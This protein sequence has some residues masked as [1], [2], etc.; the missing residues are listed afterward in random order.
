MHRTS[1]QLERRHSVALGVIFMAGLIFSCV[2]ARPTQAG[3]NRATGVVSDQLMTYNGAQESVSI[4]D[5]VSATTGL[6]EPYNYYFEVSPSLTRLVIEM[7]DPD[8]VMGTAGPGATIEQNNDRDLRRNTRDTFASYKLFDPSGA[9]VATQ[10]GVGRG[11]SPTSDNAWR[12]LYDSRTIG[13]TGGDTFSDNFTT[14]VYNRDDGSNN[15]TGDWTEVNELGT[16]GP[17]GGMLRVDASGSGHLVITNVGDTGSFVNKPGIFREVNLSSFTAANL[18]FSWST[19]GTLE[20]NDAVLIEA[21]GDGGTSWTG[22][23][24][25]GNFSSGASSGTQSYDI[26]PFIATNTRLRFSVFDLMAGTDGTFGDERFLIDTVTVRGTNTTNSA[27]PTPGHWRLI[28]DMS[29]DTYDRNF[30]QNELN[31]LAIRAHDGDSTAAGNEVHVYAPTYF[32]FGL[33]NNGRSRSYNMYPYINEGCNLRVNDFD[34]DSGAADPDGAGPITPPY[35]SW[36]LT[37]RTAAF[38]ANDGGVLSDNNRWFSALVSGWTTN[39]T[40]AD[41]GIW[42]LDLTVQDF[43]LGNYAMVYVGQQD[44]ADPNANGNGTPGPTTSPEANTHRIYFPTDANTA[45]A[46]PYVRQAVRWR[47]SGPN[48]PVMGST[49]GFAVTIAVT[50]PA[51]SIGNITF[52]ASHLISAFI[53]ADTA[54]VDY[55]YAGLAAGFPTSGTVTA[56]SLGAAGATLT[57]NPGILAPGNTATLVYRVD[58]QPLVATDPLTVPMTGLYN[59]ANATSANFIDETGNAGL[60]FVF[61]LCGLNVIAGST[62]GQTPVLVS[63]FSGRPA[64]GGMEVQWTTAAEAGTSTFELLRDNAA[65]IPQ[66]VSRQPLLALLDSPQGGT[67][68]YLDRTASTSHQQTYRL[69]ETTASGRRLMHG[70]FIVEADWQLPSG[71][72]WPLDGFERRAHP[73]E[74]QVNTGFADPPTDFAPTAVVGVDV[75]VDTRGLYRVTAQDLANAFGLPTGQIRSRIERHGLSLSY[76]GKEVT[77]LSAGDGRHLDFFA[78]PAESVHSRQAV[79]RLRLGQGVAMAKV[80]GETPPIEPGGDFFRDRRRLEKNLRPAVLLP[81]DPLGDIFFWDFLRFG[82]AQHGRKSFALDLPEVADSLGLGRLSLELQGAGTG[83]HRLDVEINGAPLGTVQVS[84]LDAGRVALDLPLDVLLP[85]GNTLTLTTTGGSLVFLNAVSVDYDRR[86]RASDEVLISR[87][88]GHRRVVVDGFS[89]PHLRVFDITQPRGPRELLGIRVLPG[90]LPAEHRVLWRPAKAS[91]PYLAISESGVLAPLEL[92]PDRQSNLRRDDNAADYLVIVPREMADAAQALAAL[93]AADGLRTQVVL[94]QDIYDEFAD[95]HREWTALR[96]FLTFTQ[97]RWSTAPRFVVLAGAGTYD[98]ADHSGLGG[99]HIPVPLASDGETLFA[100]DAV[101]ADG[102]VR[103]GLPEIAIGRLPALDADQLRALVNKIIA[104]GREAGGPGERRLLMAADNGDNI[105]TYGQD[106]DLLAALVPLGFEVENVDLETADLSQARQHLF[107]GLDD[108]VSILHYIGHGGVDRLAAEGLLTS[109]DVPAL[110]NLQ[111]PPLVIALSC[112][113]GLHGLPGFDSLGEHLL[114]SDGG[115]IAVIAPAWLSRHGEAQVLGDR[116]FRQLFVG[117]Q[118]VLGTA[119]LQAMLDAG[120][121]G[122]DP[123]LLQ[124]YQLLGDP[125]MELRLVP[126][127]LPG[128]TGCNLDCGGG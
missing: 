100:T 21:S 27:A 82:D 48:P 31:A 14:Q 20:D 87:S 65:G 23:D 15:W 73:V 28:M 40:V 126:E 118:R 108:G 77:Y 99:N 11:N 54:Q 89:D 93:R 41:Y 95:G 9:Q 25:L 68:R 70:P 92:R 66:T 49:T 125:A 6:D 124:T 33:N 38:T 105:A 45:P 17:S 46:K 7:F 104:Y 90:E 71:G 26:T 96:D 128:G 114:R 112:H 75:L 61:S 64:L 62:G 44:G 56:P 111:H 91:T 37:S 84:G 121:V 2:V 86:Y 22:L 10:F 106:S 3:G 72:P 47:G 55:S 83:V 50:N 8:I 63:S 113:I 98:W 19:G 67:Y 74:R 94:V 13:L 119:L 107:A 29:T 32:S 109:A 102:V 110:G 117:E 59:T 16:A 80:V 30:Q 24:I 51:G 43:G 39:N 122:V 5:F 69:V 53:P 76:R 78:A 79:Y 60:P 57:W 116:L 52:D 88:D 35:G 18:T 58:V 1:L 42:R 12:T 4:G 123:T 103:D 101:Y 34:F 85:D 81:L 127:D 115:A 120:A 97:R 36:S